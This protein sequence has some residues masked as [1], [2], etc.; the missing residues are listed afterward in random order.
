MNRMFLV[1][2]N[3]RKLIP[4]VLKF[5][6]NEG[7]IT[8]DGVG[9]Y[10]ATIFASGGE[11][12]TV[13]RP[14]VKGDRVDTMFHP[15]IRSNRA[16]A[17]MAIDG[18]TFRPDQTQPFRHKGWVFALTGDEVP[19]L[20]PP[21]G[22]W[23]AAFVARNSRARCPAED[24]AHHVIARLLSSGALRER[25]LDSALLARAIRDVVG[26][27][28]DQGLKR[29]TAAL[30][31][32]EMGVVVTQGRPVHYAAV[33]G[34]KEGRGAPVRAAHLRATVVVDSPVE[35]RAW[36]EIPEGKALEV[37]PLPPCRLLD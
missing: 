21:A 14:M 16:L 12:L 5:T 26:P 20:A 34:I 35:G 4:D 22:E 3:D 24:L 7:L 9:S 18:Q 11:V 15:H 32:Q 36:T 6:L 33:T 27:L 10:G 8:A 19:E 25:V 29:W 17:T 13:Q 37:G 1:T 23:E 28:S 31:S 2:T 30:T